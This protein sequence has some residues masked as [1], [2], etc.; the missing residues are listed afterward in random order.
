MYN[1]MANVGAAHVR[2]GSLVLV[3]T[4]T[5]QE[6]HVRPFNMVVNNQTINQLHDVTRGGMNLG[7]SA[8]QDIAGQIVSPAAMT[9]GVIGISGDGWTSRRFR[10]FLR[11]HEEHPVIK[12]TSTQRIFFIYTD[13]CDVSYNDRPDPN[14]RVYF[15]SETVISE[16]V[17]NTPMG[18]QKFCKVDGSSQIVTPVDMMAGNNGLFSA[19]SSHLIRP[20]DVFSIGQMTSIVDRLQN[21]G[22]FQGTINRMHDHRTMVGECGAYQYSKREDTSPVR[23][24][25]NT[26]RAFQ[27]SVHEADLLGDDNFGNV[28]ANSKEHLYGEAHSFAANASIHS[29]TFLAILKERANYMER[30]YVTWG[31]LCN[32]FPELVHQHGCAAFAMD[33][34]QSQRR[35]LFAQDS[36]H[37]HGA[38]PTSIASSTLGQTVPSLMMDNF[39]RHV[40]FAV[41]NGDRPGTYRFDYHGNMIKSIM[42]GID[43]RPYL[44]EFERRLAIDCLN[45][46]T[47]NNQ[48]PF[49]LSMSSDLAGDSVIDI[50]L[51]GEAIVRYVVPTFTD[52]LFAPIITRDQAKANKIS[53]DMLYMVSEVVPN[54]PKMQAFQAMNQP[55]QSENFMVTP[56]VH[57]TMPAAAFNPTPQGTM[58]VYSFDGL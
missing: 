38:D 51:Q 37:F 42:E 1:A 8:V 58:N 18:L 32:L 57:P 25:S 48:I 14:M 50:S 5:Y 4:G 49:T 43:M 10:G 45:T 20:E 15:N 11:A 16:R 44:M 7:V 9:E 2:I 6:Q 52:G 24:V 22:R 19:P 40:S 17:E 13:Q 21:T 29:N 30:G 34:G 27:H 33:N 54:A 35:T 39:L 36:M 41:T 28:A 12:G 31:E 26:L 56:Y 3:Q 23:Y 53:N 46:I 55:M 47:F